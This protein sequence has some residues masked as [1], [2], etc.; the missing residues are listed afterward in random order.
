MLG[1]EKLGSTVGRIQSS[2][3]KG[4]E[5]D[6]KD[7]FKINFTSIAPISYIFFTNNNIIIYFNNTYF[8]NILIITELALNFLLSTIILLS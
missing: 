2:L 4:I 8:N 5:T 7:Y 3:L 6:K 1:F